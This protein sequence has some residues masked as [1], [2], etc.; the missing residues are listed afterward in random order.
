MVKLKN[1]K[2]R[3]TS[4][5]IE[6]E[7]AIEAIKAVCKARLL[8]VLIALA[9]VITTQLTTRNL[10]PTSMPAAFALVSIVFVITSIWLLY[11]RRP[12]EKVSLRGLQIVKIMQVVQ[13]ELVVTSMLY[14]NGTVNTFTA[15]FLLLIVM[16]GSILYREKGII[17]TAIAASTI[18]TSLGLLEFYGLFLYQP[19]PEGS[20]K[21][22]TLKADPDKAI[23]Q[24]L[25]FNVYCLATA[26]YA[27]YLAAVNKK[28]EKTLEEQKLELKDKAEVLIRQTKE[29]TKA[30]N[31]LIVERNKV[32][33]VIQ[34]LTTG[35][36]M[37]D[38]EGKVVLVNQQAEA[39]LHLRAK[40]IINQSLVQTEDINLKKLNQLIISQVGQQLVK[41]EFT[42]V[43]PEECI[44]EVSTAQ[45]VD[46]GGKL[47]GQA[48]VLSD[49]T[50]GKAI[51]EMKLEFITIT[52]HQLRTPL[53]EMKWG[54][55]LLLDGDF[56][57]LNKKQKQV[58]GKDIQSNERMI[59]LI[60]DLL[61]VTRIEE[62]KFFYQ[63]AQVSL[64]ELVQSTIN[65]FLSFSKSKNIT[66]KFNRPAGDKFEAEIDQEKI[67]LVTQN[68][69]ENAINYS[70][71]KSQIVINL[72]REKQRIIL[73]IKDSG[74]GI[75]EAEKSRIFTKFFRGGNALRMQTEG[76]GLGLYIAKNIID[77]HHGEIWLESKEG[78]G[79]TFYFR[80]P[81][82]QKS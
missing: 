50:R 14:L 20:V 21:F 59:I 13:D 54:L 60:N 23:Y 34:N 64:A 79:S 81:L 18:Y 22:L 27:G 78:K 72:E 67:K 29:L 30:Q 24:I 38:Q 7:Q 73:S 51:E 9:Q 71:P 19:N 1:N 16:S 32:Q 3:R 11:I 5:Q 46:R 76:N 41:K 47:L 49:I 75:T 82:K 44:L 37:L 63:Y 52:A 35:L 48:I 62:G 15:V 4:I 2:K 8:F 65:D 69:I 56:G 66:I 36:I 31:N 12:I 77:G 17:A 80:I 10:N 68:L 70:A 42:L 39:T 43:S 55:N 26:I 53:S 25:L 61:N 57:T 6:K 45:V 74:I 40:E 58:I 28:R 33:A